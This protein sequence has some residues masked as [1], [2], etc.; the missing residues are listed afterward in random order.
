MKVSDTWSQE[1]K[2]STTR[3]HVVPHPKG[4]AVKSM[5]SDRAS[6]VHPTQQ[7]AIEAGRRIVRN[8]GGGELVIHS[9]KPI[10]PVPPWVVR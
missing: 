7:E 10:D 4:W 9:K 3:R 6:S 5:K 1:T 8:L 2:V